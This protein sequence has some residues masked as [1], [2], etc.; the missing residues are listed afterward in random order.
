MSANTTDNLTLVAPETS[1]T[2]MTGSGKGLGA[3]SFTINSG[4]GW[5]TST[6]FIVAVRTV[7]ANGNE[8]PGTYTEWAATYAGG[9]VTI[10]ATPVIGSDQ[11]YTAGTTTQVY[12]PV[13]SVA[14]N[15]LINALLNQHNQDGSHAAITAT[16]LVT[17]GGATI[18]GSVTIAGQA[19]VTPVVI[20][21][22]STITPSAQIYDVTALAASA[23]INVP[24]FSPANGMALIIRIK[25]NGTPH[26]LTFATGYSNVSGITTPT[27]TIASKL[28]TI[29]ALY[30]SATSMWEIQGINQS[31]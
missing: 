3:T 14:W 19:S 11:V 8:I 18:G 2:Y 15:R 7:D 16:S 26:T 21:S 28:L 30:N 31:A 12:I 9:T 25:D 22:N 29:G 1:V 13:S 17:S 5:P 4:A 23:T 20:T 10:N 6:G 27:T 24:S